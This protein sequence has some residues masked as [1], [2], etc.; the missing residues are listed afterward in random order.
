MSKN[1]DNLQLVKYCEWKKCNNKGIYRAP[2]NRECLRE[3]R[4]FCLE[5]VREYNKNWNY[6]SGLSQKEIEKELKADFT[7]HLPTWPMNSKN[8]YGINDELGI[9][10]Y[11]NKNNKDNKDKNNKISKAF[12]KLNLSLD[13][14]L[15]DIK[16][17]YKVLVKKYHPDANKYSKSN[18]KLIEIN[19]AYKTIIDNY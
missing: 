17:Q 18:N 1:S 12:K 15:Q 10:K 5:H 8:N 4:W 16:R 19:D 11:K 6:F 9:L 3:F 14:S 7:W 2:K 13:S